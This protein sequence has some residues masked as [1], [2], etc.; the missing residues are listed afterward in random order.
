[1]NKRGLSITRSLQAIVAIGIV[2]AAVG[3]ILA[4]WEGT[5]GIDVPYDLED[6]NK[7]SQLSGEAELQQE[8]INS[9]RQESDERFEEGTFRGAFAIVQNIFA[10]FRFVFGDNGLVDSVTERFGLPDY[11]RQGIVVMMVLA[12]T[13]AIVALVF[14]RAGGKI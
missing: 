2:I 12:I 5:Y 7:I 11:L 4:G 6:F 13:G 3:V 9:E 10:P 8:Q 14:R 1:M